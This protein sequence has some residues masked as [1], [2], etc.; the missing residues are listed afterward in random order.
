MKKQRLRVLHR[1]KSKQGLSLVELI[2]GVAIMVIVFG[3]TMSAMAN[4][5]SDTLYNAEQNVG[6]AGGA[7][8]N[9]VIMAALQNQQF[10]TEEEFDEYFAINPNDDEN[11]SVHAA[12]L[13]ISP[14]IK[15][16]PYDQF[17]KNEEGY[18]TQYT[19]TTDSNTVAGT[20]SL[21]GME[22]FTAVKT[23]KGWIRNS[24]FVAYTQQ[25]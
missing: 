23:T 9:E 4:G 19:I 18:E 3:A 10:A 16:V 2:V 24:S 22:I 12:A 21:K 15:Y 11:N 5:Y 13:S 7:S 25:E 1:M 14:E 17:P 6:A 20:R 8:V